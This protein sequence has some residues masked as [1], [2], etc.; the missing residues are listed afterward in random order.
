MM[1][2]KPAPT[3]IMN[4]QCF[5]TLSKFSQALVCEPIILDMDNAIEKI[6]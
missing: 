5:L 1:L 3:F 6:S 4:L 2:V